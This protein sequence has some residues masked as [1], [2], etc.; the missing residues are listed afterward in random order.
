M[1]TSFFFACSSDPKKELEKN[2]QTSLEIYLKAQI[3]KDELLKGSK[4]DSLV[5]TKI[6]T[7]TPLYKT[8][9]YQIE[10]INEMTHLEKLYE[11]TKNVLDKTIEYNKSKNE[12]FKSLSNEERLSV[13][14]NTS[15][16]EREIS[17]IKSKYLTY[18]NI[19]DSCQKIIDDTK[20][21]NKTL[22]GY[23]AFFRVKVT[24][25]D[26]TQQSLD[27]GMELTKDFRIIENTLEK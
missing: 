2:I 1:A 18:K 17:E 20:T 16:E 4:L 5:I 15:D 24:K 21:D 19:S 22:V 25:S 12:M 11:L 7:V 26:M 8:K 3:K 6:D 10:V 27:A 23:Y 9:I 14:T 13:Q